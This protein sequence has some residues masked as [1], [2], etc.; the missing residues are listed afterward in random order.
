[1]FGEAGCGGAAHSRIVCV[2]V[3]MRSSTRKAL[4]AEGSAKGK[5]RKASALRPKGGVWF[6]VHAL[7]HLPILPG[8]IRIAE[9]PSQ[10]LP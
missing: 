5:S 9:I 8:P 10:D 4:D 6:M 3:W 1:M 7:I 2:A